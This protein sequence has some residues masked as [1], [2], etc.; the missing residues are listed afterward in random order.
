[1]WT[2]ILVHLILSCQLLV[3]EG[4]AFNHKRS[5]SQAF[6]LSA[7]NVVSSKMAVIWN[8][9]PAWLFYDKNAKLLLECLSRGSKAPHLHE[10]V[11]GA[12]RCLPR[13]AEVSG[14]YPT[15]TPKVLKGM[16]PF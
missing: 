2:D 8:M 4:L 11:F 1:M 16:A 15:P 7:R 13:G 14:S 9:S 5:G 3:F 12:P 10:N 6:I